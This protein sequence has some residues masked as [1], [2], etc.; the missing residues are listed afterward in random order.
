[1]LLHGKYVIS[2]DAELGSIPN[3]AV[4]C[5]GGVIV[6]VGCY[7]ELKLRYPH[8]ERIGSRTQVVMP[9]L[10]NAHGHGLGLSAIQ[11]GYLDTPIELWGER[12]PEPDAYYDGAFAAVKLIRSGVTASI[13]HRGARNLPRLRAYA[14][15]GLR[16]VF[17]LAV[18]DPGDQREK[19]ESAAGVPL[20][21]S[22]YF[23]L[24]RRL[25]E[26]Y[27]S[28]R[29]V[30]IQYGPVAPQW[31]STRLL[32]RIRQNATDLGIPIHMHLLETVYQRDAMRKRYGKSA[33]EYLRDIGF[34]KADVTLAHLVW[35]SQRDI[36]IVA[37]SQ[38]R[39]VHNPSS[40]FAT[41]AGIMPLM[42]I[43]AAGITVGLGMDDAGLNDD[44]D[45]FTEMRMCLR[46]HRQPALDDPCLACSDVLEMATLNGA[47]CLSL[48]DK[49]G[50]LVPGK[51]ADVILVDFDAATYPYMDP[52][53]DIVDALVHR[54]RAA[55]VRTTV[56]DGR[57]L[58]R[59]GQVTAFDVEE[60]V[61]G[62]Q[63]S[64]QEVQR[65]Q[66]RAVDESWPEMSPRVRDHYG[67]LWERD[68]A[69]PFYVYN[70]RM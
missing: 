34:L 59:D 23:K 65:S 57:V 17:A 47:R 48:E 13:V 1:L 19:S 29:R 50:S 28:N 53:V 70:D 9:G 41:W 25:V 40:N 36:D 5:E 49:I 22:E 31:S 8:A 58:M 51:A 4:A 44:D 6:A 60:I 63:A 21:H 26:Q 43:R 38:A 55:H 68:R 18:S 62:L 39:A 12:D 11:M 10:V 54:C 27:G 16:V 32:E 45:M 42:S 15:A 52:N 14:D 46:L 33:V 24:V 20:R 67:G 64:A 35:P 3:G 69:V 66:F 37:E 2:N 7:E 30:Q 56:A 61:Q